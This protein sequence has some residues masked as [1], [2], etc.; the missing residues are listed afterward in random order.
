LELLDG[1]PVMS[2]SYQRQETIKHAVKEALELL[3]VPVPTGKGYPF[4]LPVVKNVLRLYQAREFLHEL[5]QLD[6]VTGEL[7]PLREKL[8]ELKKLLNSLLTEET[9]VTLRKLRASTSEFARLRQILAEHGATKKKVKKKIRRY[10][11]HLEKHLPAHPQFEAILK[12]L[13]KYSKGLY[14]GYNSCRI[15]LTNLEI[16]RYFNTKGFQAAHWNEQA[17]TAV[18]AR[19]GNLH[20]R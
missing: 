11:R 12:R 9:L 17:K 5:D 13:K 7:K 1:D 10:K 18:L 6:T 4:E 19:G 14:H 3:N 20:V 15:P 8:Q 2:C 16:E